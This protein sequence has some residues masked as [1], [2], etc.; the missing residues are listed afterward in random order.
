VAQLVEQASSRTFSHSQGQKLLLPQRNKSLLSA[1][2]NSMQKSGH[3]ILHLNGGPSSVQLRGLE[4]MS[5]GWT[6][7]AL[8]FAS[9]MAGTFATAQNGRAGEIAYERPD[10][11]V[12]TH[13]QRLGEDA[14]EGSALAQ[15]V[16]GAMYQLGEIVPQDYTEAAKWISRAADQG[17]A[18]AQFAL[19]RMYALGQGVP[20][21][22]VRAHMWFTASVYCLAQS[23]SRSGRPS[24]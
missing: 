14:Q 16:L 10:Y 11:S 24:K 15:Y 3:G 17:L 21:D 23:H 2:R 5:R 13:L 22:P 12:T 9:I 19:G 8:T 1:L 18:I 20:E 4:D 6:F 7:R